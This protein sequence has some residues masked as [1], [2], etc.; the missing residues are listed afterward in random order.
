MMVNNRPDWRLPKQLFVG[1]RE[2]T[3][4][5]QLQLHN[6]VCYDMHYLYEAERLLRHVRINHQYPDEYKVYKT[7][8]EYYEVPID[9]LHLGFGLGELV[10]RLIQQLNISWKVRTPTWSMVENYLTQF[11]VP[12][13]K[14]HSEMAYYLA[15]PSTNWGTVETTEAIG[16]LCEHWGW[17]I[18]D[19][20]YMDYCGETAKELLDKYKNLII[21]KT[22]SKSM[23]IAGLRI[24][25]M[26]C[27]DSK[28]INDMQRK[29]PSCVV[30]G[31]SAELFVGLLPLMQDHIDRMLE[32]KEY[33]E[34]STE[35][36]PSSANYVL[37]RDK[38]PEGI[39]S[40]LELGAGNHWNHAYYR[41][42]LTNLPLWKREVDNAA[43]V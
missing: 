1:D 40:S 23:N 30:N 42:A 21:L 6:N 2:E 37:M 18:S 38:P 28:L 16:E 35:C 3:P 25:W 39:L 15:N 24:G 11:D 41:M 9:Y 29:R 8:S 13:G 27:S 17:V 26:M 4:G 33:I 34:S 32:T 43:R 19:E 20:A 22:V 31:L 12:P 5:F 7:I 10:P 14:W 36:I